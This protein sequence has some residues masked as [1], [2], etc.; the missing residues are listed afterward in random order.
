MSLEPSETFD[1]LEQHTRARRRRASR[2]LTQL[3]ADE[4]EA[5]LEGLAKL[6][7]PSFDFFVLALLAGITL[8]FG[9]RFDQRALLVGGVLLAP[10]LAPVLGIALSAVSGS[11]RFFLRMLTSLIVACLI[12]GVVSGL[13]GGLPFGDHPT[14][15]L[16]QGHIKLNLIDFAIVMI[17]AVLITVR[18]SREERVA[19]L[20]SAA[21]A[22]ELFLPLAAGMI[23]LVRGNPELWQGALL[24]FGL[25]LAWTIVVSAI[26]LA[27]MGFR[28]LTGASYSLTA[29]VVLLGL[30]ALLGA[31]SLGASVL[32]ALPTPTATPTQTATATATPTITL[33]PTITNTPTTTPPPTITPTASPTT[34]ATPMPALVSQTGGTGAVVRLTP[35]PAA[36]HVGFVNEGTD[37]LILGGPVLIEDSVWWQVRYTTPLGETR[38]GWLQGDYIATATPGPS[39][40]P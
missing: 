12:L 6:V 32:A 3:R 36:A 1:P 13:L 40:T 18:L 19:P 2:M 8:G 15:L 34:T 22:Y 29:A 38:E 14:Y 20:P 17:A 31:T 11:P 39:P 28:P 21:I 26:T 27:A 30:M 4:R 35:D 9:F 10:R 33:T 37:M 25:H 16:A 23:G 7:S 5:F 24:T